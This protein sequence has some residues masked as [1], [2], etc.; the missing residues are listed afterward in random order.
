VHLKPLLLK[1]GDEVTNNITKVFDVHSA[2][3]IN[4]TILDPEFQEIGTVISLGQKVPTPFGKITEIRV[5]ACPVYLQEDIVVLDDIAVRA[6]N[7]L[8]V[9]LLV[10]K[11]E[12]SPEALFKSVGNLQRLLVTRI[13]GKRGILTRNILG[14]RMTN[15]GR[16][17]LLP[18]YSA[19]PEEVYIPA[20]IMEKTGIKSDQLVLV[21]RDPSIWMGSVEVLRAFPHAEDTIRLHPFVFSQFGADCDGDTVWIMRVPEEIQ[22][23]L[24][25]EILGFTKSHKTETKSPSSD[26]PPIQIDWSNP[27]V[28]SKRSSY[29]NGFS[30]SPLDIINDSKDIERFKKV[31]GKDIGKEAML[32]AGGLSN[33][34][35]NEYLTVINETVLIQK[36]YLG[37]VGAAAQKLKLVAGRH[38]LLI[39]SAN[40][41]SERAQQMLFDVKGSVQGDKEDLQVF[42]EI[43]DIINLNGA[44]RSIGKIVKHSEVIDRLRILE[45]DIELCSPMITYLY[46]VYPL[47]VVVKWLGQKSIVSRAISKDDLDTAKELCF[48]LISRSTDIDDI[49]EEI[50]TCLN[51]T[52]DEINKSMAK[53]KEQLSLG[54]IV[55]DP[56]FTL[57]NPFSDEQIVS[58]IKYLNES[59]VEGG[60][61][62]TQRLTD[63]VLRKSL[64]N[65][66]VQ[67]KF[68]RESPIPDGV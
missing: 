16:A 68:L 28:A 65:E 60:K 5:P 35:Y 30:I 58:S 63:W 44:Y 53:F 43:L 20:H 51:S 18:S 8:R 22:D 26:L 42:F 13:V 15:T 54:S 12:K 57:I 38:P 3:E 62:D 11:K 37:P 4:D 46:T 45:F 56:L 59:I 25:P 48:E 21:G 2:V 9:L 55:A 27:G 1:S 6:N 40:Y 34:K 24:V 14:R 10:E 23:R 31:T 61:L 49:Y 66:D 47:E 50:A 67:D 29:T 64:E 19:E 17:V 7:L 33:K 32:I 39:R 52:V 41:I 36:V